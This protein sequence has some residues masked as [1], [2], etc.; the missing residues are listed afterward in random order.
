MSTATGERAHAFAAAAKAAPWL[1]EPQVIKSEP[2][3]HPLSLE[4]RHGITLRR[5]WEIVHHL[6]RALESG[7]GDASPP[8]P[9]SRC[10]PT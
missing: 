8:G 4:Q 2:G 9:G 10:S 3:S 1:A 7:A 6:I 5:A